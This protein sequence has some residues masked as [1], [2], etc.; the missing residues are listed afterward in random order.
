MRALTLL[1]QVFA[2]VIL[3][4]MF[5]TGR[6]GLALR[7]TTE[8][9]HIYGVSGGTCDAANVASRI[10]DHP[11]PIA[12]GHS[13]ADSA[14]SPSVRHAFESKTRLRDVLG[15]STVRLR[16]AISI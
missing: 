16:Q 4:V 9:L 14:P 11:F 2:F 15:H 12:H 5:G 8:Q 7:R 6:R 1:G 3:T 13:Q 10:T